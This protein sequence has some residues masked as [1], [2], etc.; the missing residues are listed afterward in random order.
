M[1]KAERLAGLALARYQEEQAEIHVSEAAIS[2]RMAGASWSEIG[3]ILG[4][5][6]QGAF[7]RYGDKLPYAFPAPE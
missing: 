1:D 6:K 4:I 7:A 2:A 3:G 5:S